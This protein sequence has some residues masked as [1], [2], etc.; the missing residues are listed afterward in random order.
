MNLR[1]Y[2]G[3]RSLKGSVT[4]DAAE[5]ESMRADLIEGRKVKVEIRWFACHCHSGTKEMFKTIVIDKSTF[6]HKTKAEQTPS[7]NRSSARYWG[8]VPSWYFWLPPHLADMRPEKPAIVTRAKKKRI[9][10]S[11][12]VRILSS[13]IYPD[14]DEYDDN[15]FPF[16]QEF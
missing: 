14:L 8:A 12:E 7:W 13:G 15:D 16:E 1:T 4:I 3:L 11:E 10:T 9:V 2:H 5:G 6:L